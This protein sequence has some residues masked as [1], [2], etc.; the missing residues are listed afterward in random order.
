MTLQ[1]LN[2]LDKLCF[3]GGYDQE[4]HFEQG[5]NWFIEFRNKE[6][7][8]LI[9]THNNIGAGLTQQTLSNGVLT[10]EVDG[11]TSSITTSGVE[12][13]CEADQCHRHL[14]VC[15]GP[16]FTRHG[17]G[18]WYAFL[19]TVAGNTGIASINFNGLGARTIKKASGGLTTDLADNDIRLGQP[20]LLMYDGTNMQMHSTSGNAPTGT[21]TGVSSKAFSGNALIPDGTNC[22]AEIQTLNSGPRRDVI[23]CNN[24]ASP[25]ANLESK[26]YTSWRSA[27]VPQAR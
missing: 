15:H 10:R 19:P 17:Q 18:R 22:V 23:E 8:A 20:V 13:Y 24:V 26:Q 27:A 2:A 4:C 1:V 16:A 3:K 25:A 11:T 9:A 12:N 5:G 6:T 14:Y 7:N 21:G